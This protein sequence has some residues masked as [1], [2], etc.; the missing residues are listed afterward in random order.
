MKDISLWKNIIT[1]MVVTFILWLTLNVGC[2]TL[3]ED[4]DEITIYLS[5]GDR[6][7]GKVIAHENDYLILKNDFLGEVKIKKGFVV[8]D[9][10]RK[11][12]V[13]AEP[14]KEKLWTIEFA[15][16]SDISEGNTVKS[17]LS[18][19]L[20]ANR[21]ASDNE[22]TIKGSSSYAS[23]DREMDTQKW[24]GMIRYAYSFWERKWYNFYKFEADHDRF[25][26]IDYRLI[27]STGIGYWFSD[28]PE[29]KAMVEMGLG[30]ENTYFR[31]EEPTKHEVALTPRIFLEKRLIGNAIIS[32]E[33]ILYPSLN[34]LG[35]Y[36]LHSATSLKS[37]LTNNIFL[38][39][40]IIDNYNSSPSGVDIKR[41]DFQFITSLG[42]TY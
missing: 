32:Q 31:D 8:K 2:I 18:A 9:D 16:G 1:Y 38:R 25:A 22:F 37:P 35:D 34:Y 29:W 10:K 33:I 41:N 42:Y 21:K 19:D 5:N 40:S 27:P 23:T 14:D 24:Y 28:R 30:L 13:A 20:Y 12:V 15:L 26:N 17:S 11:E 6:I 4:N 36:R 39:F 3:G 7:S